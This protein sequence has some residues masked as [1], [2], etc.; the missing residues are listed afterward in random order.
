V[1]CKRAADPYFGRT[2]PPDRQRLCYVL[3][4]EPD[5]LDPAYYSGGFEGYVM[6]ALFEGLVSYH[7]QTLQPMAALA[8]HFEAVADPSQLTFWLRGHPHPRGEAFPNTNTL[9][10]QHETG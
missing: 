10:R 8:T 9:R 6:Q 2:T 7:P 3:G 1:A 4:A 5:S